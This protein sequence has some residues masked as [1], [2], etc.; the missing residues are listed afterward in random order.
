MWSVI[1]GGGD[2]PSETPTR[3]R[4]GRLARGF[5]R[6]LR[7]RQSRRAPNPG[8]RKRLAA[9]R[10]RYAEAVPGR[11]P[12]PA[13]DGAQPWS[14]LALVFHDS[15]GR[16]DS[17]TTGLVVG[18]F[19]LTE[20]ESQMSDNK[21]VDARRARGSHAASLDQ[22]VIKHEQQMKDLGATRE[23]INRHYR[24]CAAAEH[25]DRTL[26]ATLPPGCR[27]DVTVTLPALDEHP[28]R[29]HIFQ[30][31]TPTPEQAARA[32]AVHEVQQKEEAEVTRRAGLTRLSTTGGVPLSSI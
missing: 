11:Q 7:H 6:P 24:A 22:L 17:G 21:I 31:L 1:P 10:F 14:G 4:Q 23:A 20:E 13:A 29:H 26:E 3:A 5:Y 16:F 2:V 25:I 32:A 18:Q 9:C 12:Q 8:R 15:G 30:M 28:P 27:A 19:T